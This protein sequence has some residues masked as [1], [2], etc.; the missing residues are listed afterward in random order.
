M[1]AAA[2]IAR[3]E[4]A[5]AS[6][7][8][9][10]APFDAAMRGYMMR[11]FE[12]WIR[13]GACLQVGCA[14]GD[15]TSLLVE[16]FASVTVVEAARP[17]IEAARA[18]VGDKARFV[19]SLIEAYDTDERYDTILFSHVLEHVDDAVVALAKLKSLLAPGGRLFVI[20]PNAEAASR[21]IAVKMGVLEHLEDL[22]EADV[23]AGHRRVYRLDT[24]CRDVTRAGLRIADSG[25][26]F[27]KP[28]ANFQFNALIG[29]PLISE[30]FMEGCYALGREHPTFCA[31]IY[32]VAE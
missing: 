8:E 9:A 4:E 10:C 7:G 22:S 28:L 11:T 12:P 19:E 30:A 2:E 21:R 14:H 16:R 15:Q 27:F 26:V 13:E 1:S 20:V 29:G 23:G 32:V 5:I 24:L 17:F 6:Y 18:V 25:G 3:L 31:S